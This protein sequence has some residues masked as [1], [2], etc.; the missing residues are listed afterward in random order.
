[1]KLI[2]HGLTGKEKPGVII[3]DTR[4]DVSAFFSDYDQAFFES[5]G[6]RRLQSIIDEQGISLPRVPDDVRLGCPVA[7]ISKIVCVGLNYTDHAAEVGVGLPKEPIIFL[8]STTAVNGPHDD[9]IIPKTSE[10][11][12][13]EIELAVVM[14]KRASYLAEEKVPGYI[15]GYIM[16]ND[17]S[18]RSFMFDRNGTWDKGK[19]CDTFAPL[20]PF[21]ATP[22]EIPDVLALNIWLKLNGKPMQNGHTKD[23]IFKPN[24]LIAYIT[25]FMTLLPGDIVSTGSPAGV[26]FGYKP[27]VFLREGDMIESGIDGLGTQSQT[28]KAYNGA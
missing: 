15:A 20:G 28:L 3:N 26:G 23:M 25:Q 5:D 14:G 8:K 22:D 10:K 27:P 2:R 21:M 7:N 19:G 6:L 18:E 9:I 12:D 13:W 24:Y 17:V 1:M 16:H 11:T 4:Y